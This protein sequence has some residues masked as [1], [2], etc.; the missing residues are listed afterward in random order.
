[1]HMQIT[2]I[3]IIYMLARDRSDIVKDCIFYSFTAS[4]GSKGTTAG[5]VVSPRSVMVHRGFR[6][7]VCNKISITP[8]SITFLTV[9]CPPR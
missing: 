3:M 5:H 6:R 9:G 8:S 2:I 7:E 1:M 4:D